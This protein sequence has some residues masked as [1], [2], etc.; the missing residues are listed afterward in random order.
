MKLLLSYLFITLCIFFTVHSFAAGKVNYL[1]VDGDNVHFAT[2][3]GKI[4]TSPA[5]AVEA[6]KD[7]F[8]VSLK[9]EAGRAIYSLLVT[10]MSTNEPVDVISANDCADTPGLERAQSVS[11]PSTTSNQGTENSTILNTAIEAYDSHFQIKNGFRSHEKDYYTYAFHN[12]KGSKG[13]VLTGSR[14]QLVNVTGSGWLTAILTPMT[15][16]NYNNKSTLKLEVII[17]GETKTIELTPQLYGSRF[18]L[19]LAKTSMADNINSDLFYHIQTPVHVVN[20]GKGIRFEQNMEVWLTMG[21]APPEPSPSNYF[22]V[23]Y[24][25]GSSH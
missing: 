13:A 3:E 10:A 22:G 14:T 25:R 5:C 2:T 1:K 24:I 23:H 17:D 4:T 8:T 18:F 20:E 9:T 11:L 16:N 6:S 12:S 15:I 21:E 7:Y 19:G